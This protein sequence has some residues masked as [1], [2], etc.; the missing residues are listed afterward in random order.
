MNTIR[1]DVYFTH[2]QNTK[3]KVADKLTKQAAHSQGRT[4][5]LRPG[6]VRERGRGEGTW[7][8]GP[9][10]WSREK[11]DLAGEHTVESPDVKS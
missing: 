7:G 9:A 8:K 6:G 2:V 10:T 5:E 1:E 4:A 11:P 3:Q